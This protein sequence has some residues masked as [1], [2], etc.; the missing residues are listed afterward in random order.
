MQIQSTIYLL[1]TCSALWGVVYPTMQHDVDVKTC[2]PSKLWTGE[3][4]DFYSM[5]DSCLPD[6]QSFMKCEYTKDRQITSTIV[7]CDDK[8][9]TKCRC[10]TSYDYRTVCECVNPTPRPKFPGTGVLRWTG[11][12]FHDNYWSGSGE[13]GHPMQVDVSG[14]VHKDEG[15]GFMMRS[16]VVEWPYDYTSDEG[17]VVN[18]VV[19]MVVPNHDG[20]N[21]T[22][23]TKINDGK[24]WK[25]QVDREGGDLTSLWKEHGEVYFKLTSQKPK[26]NDVIAQTWEQFEQGIEHDIAW[27][28]KMEYYAKNNVAIPNTYEEIKREPGYYTK[29]QL[30]YRYEQSRGDDASSFDIA[31]ICG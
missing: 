7:K 28:W 11:T 6:G 2:G 18:T 15:G 12:E 29:T 3:L 22:E 24:C 26:A 4:G 30:E 8:P 9:N 27:K 13:W 17:P 25:K 10:H 21:F 31:D 20:G 16:M 14:E 19:I 5:D 1:L 23:Y